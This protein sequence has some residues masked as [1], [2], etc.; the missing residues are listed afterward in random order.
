MQFIANLDTSVFLYIFSFSGSPQDIF[1]IFLAEYLPF[2]LVPLFPLLLFHTSISVREKLV[3]ASTVFTIGLL[4]RFSIIPIIR[5]FYE[6]P[7]PFLSL[8]IEP[9]FIKASLSF[10]SGHSTYFFAFATA[11]YCYNKVW[12]IWFFIAAVAVTV[13]RIMAG[14]HYPADIIM[15]L[16]I[17]VSIG[18]LSYQLTLSLF[19]KLS[20]LYLSKVYLKT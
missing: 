1:I 9:L 7:R 13:A 14:V 10:P 20:S 11:I 19:R 17:G 15:G 3:V 8:E 12:G 18:L 2:I 4:A 6:R 5:L 16:I